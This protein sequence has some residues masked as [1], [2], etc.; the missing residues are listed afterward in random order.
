M[1][2]IPLMPAAAPAAAPSYASKLKPVTTP[3][4]QAKLKPIAPPA[5]PAAQPQATAGN[6]IPAATPIDWTKSK[7]PGAPTGQ[8]IGTLGGYL[9]NAAKEKLGLAPKGSTARYDLS[10]P[11][12]KEVG[13]DIARSAGII[14]GLAAAPAS[15]GGA[16]LAGGASGAAIAGGDTAVKKG[17]TGDIL[18][19]AA[20]GGATGAATSGA[21]TGF[22]KLLSSAGQKITESV[23]KPTK[24]DIQDGFSVHTISKYD[25]GGSLPTMLDKT[26]AKL[27][28][29]SKELSTKLAASGSKV[30][31]NDV[32]KST[33][34]SLVGN[35]LSSF[36]SNTSVSGA[37]EQL[38]GEI[39]AVGGETG[40]LS[41]PEA[42]TVKRAAGNMGAW[43]FGKV[44]PESSAREKVYNAFY[45]ELKQ[46]I[47][48]NSPEGVREINK[49]LSELIPVSNAIV[50]R[51][52][53]AARNNIL[54]LTDIISLTAG[55]MNPHA[56]GVT[57][58]NLASK[59]GATG[60]FL[61]KFAPRMRSASAPLG[62]ALGGAIGSL[63]SGTQ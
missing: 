12:P 17:S 60:D 33:E 63:A 59:S 35:K 10:A 47:E 56:L 58:L 46:A 31:L 2:A 52:P 43:Q 61:S 4:Y 3:S 40:S 42:Q 44:D 49:Q 29:L 27:S 8:A 16:A 39:G 15:I 41:V 24:A 37:L 30:N 50:R 20:I 57:M 62:G 32:F 5:A 7:L 19:S 36:G 23:I 34:K 18:K 38:K 51:I 26:D 11:S 48:K 22:S 21:F 55:A 1:A 54:S 53:V 13:G 14:G 45:K 25:L 28:A 6:G 9:F